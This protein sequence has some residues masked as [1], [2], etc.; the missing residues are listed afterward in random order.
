MFKISEK[1][2]IENIQTLKCEQGFRSSLLTFNGVNYRHNEISLNEDGSVILAYFFREGMTKSSGA[3]FSAHADWTPRDGMTRLNHS[4]NFMVH[5]GRSLSTM[6][7]SAGSTL[8][9]VDSFS[10]SSGE[11]A[12]YRLTPL[13]F[14]QASDTTEQILK[15]LQKSPS[16]KVGAIIA[17]QKGHHVQIHL[18]AIDKK[19]A[20]LISGKKDIEMLVCRRLNLNHVDMEHKKPEGVVSESN[21]TVHDMDFFHSIDYADL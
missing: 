6:D 3:I 13:E 12:N 17:G 2:S 20:P 10:G 5:H 14:K 19:I 4:Y 18:S 11:F 1:N 21:T 8:N 7:F 15:F 16:D 9:H